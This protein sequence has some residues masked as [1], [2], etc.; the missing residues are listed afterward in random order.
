VLLWGHIPI[1]LKDFVNFANK[2]KKL[3]DYQISWIV[4]YKGKPAG[5]IYVF[6]DYAPAVRSMNGRIFPLG[7]I[8]FWI[9]KRKIN[10]YRVILLGILKK[11][12]NLGLESLFIK[13]IGVECPK[14]GYLEGEFS[15]ILESN[16]KVIGTIEHSGAKRYKTYR[17]FDKQI[18][19]TI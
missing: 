12:R 9:N 11:Y 13:M 3:F 8:N 14:G 15:W 4:E 2:N 18:Q 17:I 1:T 6:P 19:I 7:F 5:M 16:K 10:K